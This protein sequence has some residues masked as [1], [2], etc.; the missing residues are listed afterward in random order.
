MNQPAP[1]TSAPALRTIPQ[2]GWIALDG[3]LATLV[4]GTVDL[5]L[6]FPGTDAP[7][8][9]AA[10][11]PGCALPIAAG[12]P[13]RLA[14]RA[15]SD[16]T[17][18]QGVTPQG[19]GLGL[20]ALARGAGRSEAPGPV[21]GPD[22]FAAR[23]GALLTEIVA[24][25]AARDAEALAEAQAL[26]AARARDHDE[27]LRDFGRMLDGRFR[28]AGEGPAATPLVAAAMRLAGEFGV[29]SVAVQ[30][31]GEE[32][33]GDFL[34]RFAT[35]HRLRPRRVS[36]AGAVPEGEGPMLGFRRD[37]EPVLVLSRAGGG[38]RFVDPVEGGR[39]IAATPQAWR[40]LEPELLA[41]HPTLPDGAVTFRGVL[42]LAL[43]AC[44]G[45]AFLIGACLT[46]GALLALLP[47]L[48]TAQAAEIGVY[49]RDVAFLLNLVVVLI[50]VAAA[51]T[52]FHVVG[53]LAQIRLRGRAGLA[54][55]AAIMD[56]LLRLPP[57]ALRTTSSV[58][59][60]T[61]VETVQRV[62]QSVLML[63]ATALIALA[64]G[65]AAAFVVGIVSPPSGLVALALVALLLALTL[66]IGWLQFKAI[67][68]GERM[69]VVV[70][71]FAYDVVRLL[72]VLRAARA[73]QRVFAQWGQNFL[74][75][76]SRLRRS[77]LI[78]AVAVPLTGLW[79][80]VV[81]GTGFVTLAF[82]DSA[83]GLG[84]AQAIVFV[85]ALGRLIQA[86]HEL[87]AGLMSA[88]KLA[89]MTKL[90]RPLLDQRVE[91]PAVGRPPR[92]LAGS[93]ALSGVTFGYGGRPV[94][95]GLDLTIR[96]GEFVGIVGPSGSGKSTLIRLLLA[97]EA[98]ASGRILIGGQDIAHL[99]RREIARHIGAVLQDGRL[100]PGTILEN[101]RG[102]GAIGLEAAWAALDTVGLGDDLRA[103]PL[104]LHTP[105]S[106][107]G[108]SS[109]QVKQ[110][111]LTRT[112]AQAPRILILD[113]TMATL[114]ASCE[115]RV[116]TAVRALPITRI[117]VSH[118]ASALRHADRIL[119]LREGR[120]ADR[121]ETGPTA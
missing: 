110:L 120:L 62:C 89:P 34:E 40:D 100:L 96:E 93:L 121:P 37:G 113:E 105:V 51:E 42:R 29:K 12:L 68:E 112:L 86:G 17:M 55:Q 111:L 72:P 39:G 59:L 85:M 58:I 109:G 87:S 4:S 116:L 94:L 11:G 8:L 95:A 78:A 45:D 101:I 117:V 63:G 65:L 2:G 66:L 88:A 61:Q 92:R 21:E 97:L 75:F 1:A 118:R 54:V 52:V 108:L 15:G 33:R 36:H 67:Y 26:D 64:N 104:G 103:L 69:D 98:P 30:P 16:A 47:P 22:A 79:A 24:A 35:A 99:D 74:A 23:S 20:A 41:F 32:S 81:L 50:G 106:A 119:T 28:R 25:L 114:D 91:P 19:A 82:T 31:E 44:L 76:Q 10:F 48:A 18:A 7:R 90:A 70:M 5:Y 83:Y 73:E 57:A 80:S 27:T 9:V 38:C 6:T 84:A 46:V 115:E 53:G 107:A 102:A 14:L 56:R 3:R 49:N 43:R 13:L 60:A 71:S 77:G